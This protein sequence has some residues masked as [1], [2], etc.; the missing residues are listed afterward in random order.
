VAGT[1]QHDKGSNSKSGNNQLAVTMEATINWQQQL[2]V[3]W[4]QQPWQQQNSNSIIQQSKTT[5]NWRQKLTSGNKIA[6]S[7]NNQPAIRKTSYGSDTKR[8][9]SW[10]SDRNNI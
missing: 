4:W 9:R 1:K 2:A 5:I 6:K 7:G 3:T 10:H 8:Q